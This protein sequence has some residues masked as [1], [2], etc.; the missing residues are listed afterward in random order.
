MVNQ[1]VVRLQVSVQ[2]HLGMQDVHS[3]QE[4]P[5]D[6]LDF[7]NGVGILSVVEL[8]GEHLFAVLEDAVNFLLSLVVFF[9]DVQ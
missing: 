1:N 7:G 9:E 8:I 6:L 5:H 2:D 4:F 3:L